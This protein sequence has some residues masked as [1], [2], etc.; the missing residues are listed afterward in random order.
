MFRF[1]FRSFF[2]LIINNVYRKG[3]IHNLLQ[4]T[5]PQGEVMYHRI[6]WFHP[7][8]LVIFHDREHSLSSSAS[9]SCLILNTITWKDGAKITH[10]KIKNTKISPFS[11][12]YCKKVEKSTF[13]CQFSCTT[14]GV[15]AS[16][17]QKIPQ[18][19]WTKIEKRWREIYFI[20]FF[21]LPL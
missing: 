21:Y 5:T 18:L 2:S 16:T 1:V 15:Q 4:H 8:L 9:M 19:P 11:C 3:L 13:S 12:F 10:F 6:L 7:K 20:H 17:Y 14:K